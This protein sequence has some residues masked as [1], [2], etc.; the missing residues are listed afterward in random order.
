M[1]LVFDEDTS[2]LR[3]P[4]AAGLSAKVTVDTAHR[5]TLFGFGLNHGGRR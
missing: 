4:L 2:S 3:V 5:R 1:R